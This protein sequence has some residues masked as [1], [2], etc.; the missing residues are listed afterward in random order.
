MRPQGPRVRALAFSPV[1]CSAADGRRR[2]PCCCSTQV[3]SKRRYAVRRLHWCTPVSLGTSREGINARWVRS[4]SR[5]LVLCCASQHLCACEMMAA[6]GGQSRLSD[7]CCHRPDVSD[8]PVRVEEAR[9]TAKT[10]TRPAQ[11]TPARP[12]RTEAGSRYQASSPDHYWCIP[13]GR[14]GCASVRR[15]QGLYLARCSQVAQSHRREFVE[16]ASITSQKVLSGT[17]Q[18]PSTQRS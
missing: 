5:R 2:S 8:G 12:G 15:L 6:R 7:A 16:Q 10:R 14:Q 4:L 1:N 13:S 18:T 9:R 3:K 11:A 17:T